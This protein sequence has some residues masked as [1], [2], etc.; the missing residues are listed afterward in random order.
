[1]SLPADQHAQLLSRLAT[2]S[3]T[4]LSK[5]FGI[6]RKSIWRVRQS[7][8]NPKPKKM[9][10][11]I[12][13][14]AP[15][16]PIPVRAIPQVDPVPEVAAREPQVPVS[17]S[18]PV[19]EAPKVEVESVD[20]STH[21]AVQLNRGENYK[22]VVAQVLNEAN[23]LGILFRKIQ[24]LDVT[25]IGTSN[26]VRLRSDLPNAHTIVARFLQE[27]RAVVSQVGGQYLL[28]FPNGRN[29]KVPS[30]TM[31]AANRPGFGQTYVGTKIKRWK[32]QFEAA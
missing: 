24:V 19:F 10:N 29:G 4:Q 5:A 23:K 7:L 31:C 15:V 13:P 14:P 11:E 32:A 22:N 17:A 27:G 3:D 2:E 30:T 6:S 28:R 20:Y 12:A 9:Q 18:K 26:F 16:E 8:L 21:F 1:V 25:S